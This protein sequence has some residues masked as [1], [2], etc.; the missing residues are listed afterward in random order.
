MNVLL[1][2][3]GLGTR[4]RPITNE[5]PKCLVRVGGKPL[6]SYWLETLFAS[7][8]IGRVMI[9]THYLGHQ[10]E[11]FILNSKWRNR[12]TLVHEDQL[13]GTAGT[14]IKNKFFFEGKEF[15][16]IHADNFSVFDFD[17]F[18]K[19]HHAR[20]KNCVMT[21]MTYLTSNP[22]TCG[23]LTLNSDG[24]VLKMDE[25]IST[26]NHLAN[27]AVYIFEN[28]IFNIIEGMNRNISD[29]STELIKELEG[30][31]FTYP[32][33]LYHRDIGTPI[34]FAQANQDITNLRRLVF[35]I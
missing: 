2:A 10:V 12:I 4:L 31:I 24:I 9:N 23:T 6:L 16:V 15:S 5:M 25:K 32:N 21:M 18:I 8:S 3:A 11:N 17:D 1:L 33:Y 22:S 28:S 26:T 27:G 19:A 20:P 35:S 30:M 13:L 29:I 14:I 7:K 34:S